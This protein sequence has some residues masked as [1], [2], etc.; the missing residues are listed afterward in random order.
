MKILYHLTVLPPKIPQAEALSQE[1]SALQNHF[2]GELNYL[3]PNQRAPIPIPRLLFGF[4][5]LTKL[6]SIEGQF[7]LHH[8]YN[9]DP[10]PF[11]VLRFLRRPVVYTVSSGVGATRPNL[12]YFSKLTAIAVN[13]ERSFK[14]LRGWGLN[15]IYRTLPGIDKSRFTYTPLPLKKEIRL[16]AASAPWTKAQFESKGINALLQAA[17]QEPRLRIIFLW[18]G[19]LYREMA[20]KVQRLGLEEQVQVVNSLVNVN[21]ALASVHAAIT[22]AT[23]E[24]IVKAYPHSLLDALA[25][26]K[27]A[28]V[29]KTIPM[30]DYVAE[31]GCGV[32][33]EKLSAD[34][35][36]QAVAEL[37]DNY[38]IMQKIALEKGKRDFSLNA[39]LMSYQRLYRNAQTYKFSMA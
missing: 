23:R 29:S 1:I 16:L 27:P 24:G 21:K 13:D 30:A 10:F 28:L 20:Q 19:V 14:R 33:V 39:M 22:L 3:N 4:Q 2:G 8:F 6:R 17:K 5:Q 7:S 38:Q 34:H 11:P 32:V 15:N 25:A 18:R 9:P 36:L 35:I 37:S 26:G 31:T 12:S